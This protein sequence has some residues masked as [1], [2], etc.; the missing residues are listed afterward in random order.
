MI[1]FIIL[2]FQTKPNQTSVDI[3]LDNQNHLIRNVSAQLLSKILIL[4]DLTTVKVM[5]DS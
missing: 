5:K 2:G 1:L 4:D 3:F